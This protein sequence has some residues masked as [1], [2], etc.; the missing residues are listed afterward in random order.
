METNLSISVLKGV[1]E[2]TKTYLNKL[3]IVTIDDLLHNYPRSYE[4]FSKPLK[5]KDMVLDEMNSIEGSI[6]ASINQLAKNK[7]KITKTKVKDDTGLINIIWFNQLY[8]KNKLNSSEKFIFKGKVE[9]KYGQ[10]QMLSPEIYS[11]DEYTKKT[12]ALQPI[13]SLTKGLTQN[14]M[15]N[16]VKQGLLKTRNQLKEFLPLEIR[17]A[18]GFSEYNYSINQ[19]HYPFNM[20]TYKEA[21]K[22]L[23]FDEFLLFQMALLSLKTVKEQDST[24]V[25]IKDD[26]GI[27]DILKSLPFELTK[28]QLRVW[29]EIKDDLYSNKVMNRL[30][31]GDV[32]SGKTIIA[33]LALALAAKNGYQGTIMVP[34]EVLAKQHYISLKNFLEPFNIRIGLLVGSMTLKEKKE[35]YNNIRNKEIDIIVGTHALIQEKVTYNNLGLVI[36]DEQHR[37]GVKQRETLIQKGNNPH[38]LVMSATPIPRTLA[39]IVYGD[40]DVS[41]IDELPPNRQTIKTYAVDTSYRSR[42]YSFIEK[43]IQKG[44]QVYIICPMVEES[45]DLDLE[46]VVEYTEKLKQSINGSIKISYL[47]GKMKGKEKNE[48]MEDFADN[49][50]QVLVSTTVVEVGVNVPNA[51]IMVIENSERFGLA[52]LHQLRGRVGRGEHQSFCILLT[53]TKNE[54]TKERLDVLSK[55]NNGFIISEYDLKLR[56]QGD[57]FGIRQHGLV[58]FKL[59][60][61]F[62]DI[63]LLKLANSIAKKIYTKDPDLELEAHQI[64]KQ[65]LIHYIKSHYVV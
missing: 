33:A 65:R 2:K 21:R 62:E 40:L 64:L 15:N 6:C 45:E 32:G 20:K 63:E 26:T 18:H 28:A 49:K 4:S 57:L 51:T 41:I 42:V 50:I 16:F 1:G 43:E 34:T 30:L 60:N 31:Q 44:R 25:I 27:K 61:V 59:G 46:S 23:V 24:D 3:G 7:I 17:T 52:Q 36:T 39:L 5:I 10:I 55:H 11:V 8:I 29:N 58:E 37:F 54:K 9:Y 14:N 56:G 22:R 48:I 53:D 35:M 13:Y 19:I 38:I 12:E 47:H